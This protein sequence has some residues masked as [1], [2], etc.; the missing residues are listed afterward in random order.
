[1]S[2]MLVALLCQLGTGA[3][4]EVI[5][6]DRTTLQACTIQGQIGAAEWMAQNPTYSKG[7]TLQ[8]WKCVP[9]DYQKARGA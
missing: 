1:M 6:T 7:W 3:C 9:P 4:V 5:I 2:V 8:R